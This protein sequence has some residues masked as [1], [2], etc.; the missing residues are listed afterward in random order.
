LE[1]DNI[2]SKILEETPSR[3]ISITLSEKELR[4]EEEDLEEEKE[5]EDEIYEEEEIEMYENHDCPTMFSPKTFES[6]SFA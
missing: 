5:N 6:P 4:V 2:I 1:L 3:E